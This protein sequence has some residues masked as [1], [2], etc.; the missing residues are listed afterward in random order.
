[1]V[2]SNTTIYQVDVPSSNVKPGESGVSIVASGTTCDL[3]M[4]WRYSYST[5]LVPA[6]ISDKG[7]ASV[8]VYALL[9]SFI[10]RLVDTFEEQISSAVE[11]AICKKLG[12]GILKV[13]SFLQAL[14]KE[15]QVNDNASF[16]IT[17]AEKPLLSNSS[18]GLKINGLFREREKLPVHEYHFEKSPS[19]SCTVVSISEHQIVATTNVDM[20]ID[21]VEGGDQIPVACISLMHTSNEPDFDSELSLVPKK[22]GKTDGSGFWIRL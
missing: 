4:D 16:D 21:V 6:E 2:L 13:D 9:V 10:N 19:A 7:Q 15:V 22:E 18:I 5:W 12:K 14:P 11:K 3:S 8:Q 20:I 17:F 1:M